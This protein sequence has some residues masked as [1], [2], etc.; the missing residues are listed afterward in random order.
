MNHLSQ[1]V[2]LWE[3]L[4][5]TRAGTNFS[6]AVSSAGSRDTD[7]DCLASRVISSDKFMAD[8]PAAKLNQ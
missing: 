8:N 2:S 1:I 6:A 7:L 4:F 5:P 3:N